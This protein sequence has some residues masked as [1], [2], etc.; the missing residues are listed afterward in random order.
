MEFIPMSSTG[1]HQIPQDQVDQTFSNSFGGNST[2]IGNTNIMPREIL[3]TALGHHGSRPLLFIR[4]DDELLIYRVFR[5]AK[6]HLKVRFR[7]LK[8]DI[9][10]TPFSNLKA[11]IELD[12]DED[13]FVVLEKNTCKLRY[14]SNIAGYNGVA[15]CGSKPYFIL[16][17]SR[18]EL[19]THRLHHEIVMKSFAPFNN[20][21][22]PNGF[23]YFDH[24]YE[25]KI[26]VF[27]SY[28]T[29]DASWP[30]RKVP[31]RCS[32][33]QIVYHKENKVYCVV[34]NNAE[35]SNKYYRFNGEDKELTEENKGERFLYPLVDKFSVVLVTP[36]SWEII[37]SATIDLDDWEHVISLKN[38][39]LSYEGARSG[40]K[41]YICVGTNYNYSEDVTSRGRV[42]AALT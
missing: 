33:A 29:Y 15:V 36:E 32:P 2:N 11:E 22:C 19:R 39:S 37:P 3:M 40:L 25:L 17:T 24:D 20:V 18:G 21:N 35:P 42:S 1:K 8:H 14:F 27:P 16:L 38:V 13:M 10:Y 7:R 41:E 28:L 30:V 26:S 12:D 9:V 5:Y 31:L 23:L 6:G 34:M 4:L